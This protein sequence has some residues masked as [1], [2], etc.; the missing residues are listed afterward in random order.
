MAELHHNLHDDT[1]TKFKENKSMTI[2]QLPHHKFTQH[3]YLLYDIQ[4]H[5]YDA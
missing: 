5:Q 1:I 2:R 3:S 4:L